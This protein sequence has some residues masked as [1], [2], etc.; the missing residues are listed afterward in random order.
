MAGETWGL[1]SEH[2]PTVKVFK[3]SSVLFC[4]VFSDHQQHRYSPGLQPIFLTFPDRWPSGNLPNLSTIAAKG[5]LSGLPDLTVW[6][7]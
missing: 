4:F 7:L 3:S 5:R 1:L 6:T 2:T